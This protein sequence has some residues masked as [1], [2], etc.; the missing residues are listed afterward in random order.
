ME[1]LK[2]FEKILQ[3][4][5]TQ[6][7]SFLMKIVTCERKCYNFWSMENLQ[8]IRSAELKSF[9]KEFKG[10]QDFWVVNYALYGSSIPIEA[11]LGHDT[12][13]F[14]VLCKEKMMLVGAYFGKKFIVFDFWR[15][16]AW[17]WLRNPA[18]NLARKP[19]RKQKLD[20]IMN[21]C[22]LVVW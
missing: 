10:I 13:I 12:I 17:N 11:L 3:F 9:F 20:K 19:L 15:N 8:K 22:P 14:Y 4:R 6:K 1:T 5:W 18:Q 2:F 16:A 7:G 21:V